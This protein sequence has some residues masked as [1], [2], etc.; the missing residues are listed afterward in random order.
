MLS[1]PLNG[2]WDTKAED[3]NAYLLEFCRYKKGDGDFSK[4]LPIMAI[5]RLLTAEEYRGELTLRYELQT[6]DNI[7]DISLALEDPSE[8]E[9]YLD[10][11]RISSSPCGY[12]HD[13]TFEKV[14]L[15]DL[16]AGKHTLE[17]KRAFSPL[18]KVT[19][20]LT[21]LFETRHGVELEP[22]YLLG[23]FS[24]L[25]HRTASQNGS[26]TFARDF[27]L[28]KKEPAASM[29]EL[30]QEGYP[31]FVGK[32]ALTKRFTVPASFDLSRA[33]FSLGTMNAACAE[34]SLNGKAMGDLYRAPALLSLGDAL[35]EGENEI[36][37]RLFTTL[38]N[39][40]GPFHRPLGNVGNTFG[41]GYK[42]PDAA[43][44][45]VDTTAEAWEMHMEDF[46][47][48]WTDEYNVAPLGIRDAEIIFPI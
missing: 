20:P 7:Q 23:R 40:I 39:V 29:G 19:N 38:H 37:V 35:R 4:P 17:I 9:I 16:S 36:T 21:Q 42:N 2:A 41:G 12:F 6:I 31:F 47:P 28:C 25:G 3:E 8:Q 15:G 48:N 43:W 14:P 1:L 46:Y 10:G 5:H 34:I 45:S 11:K 32:I 27:T 26:I 18:T 33:R 13:Y 30:T 22:M 44:L 24:V